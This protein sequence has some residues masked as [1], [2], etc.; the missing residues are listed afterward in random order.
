MQ[1][2]SLIDVAT[3]TGTRTLTSF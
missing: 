2:R 1:F 3:A